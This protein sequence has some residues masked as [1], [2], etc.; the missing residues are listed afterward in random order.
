[1]ENRLRS[2]GL[3]AGPT[4]PFCP[5]PIA[6]SRRLSLPIRIAP[7]WLRRAVTVDSWSGIQLEVTFEPLVVRMPLVASRSLGAYGTP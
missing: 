2:Q 3:R 7:A 4:S 1:M 5:L 6:N